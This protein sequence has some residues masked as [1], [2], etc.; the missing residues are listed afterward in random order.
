MNPR[1]CELNNENVHLL[2]LLWISFFK[3]IDIEN[4]FRR[5]YFERNFFKDHVCLMTTF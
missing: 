1:A 5:I 3:E 2:V 4:T